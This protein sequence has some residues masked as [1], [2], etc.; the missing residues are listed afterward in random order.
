MYTYTPTHYQWTVNAQ[1]K[2]TLYFALQVIPLLS[3]TRTTRLHVLQWLFTLFR[4]QADMPPPSPS[5]ATSHSHPLA[6]SC[7]SNTSNMLSPRG[8][9]TYPS[10]MYFLHPIFIC[11]PPL[12][13]TFPSSSPNFPRLSY[14]LLFSSIFLRGSAFL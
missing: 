6:F 4:A 14:F 10:R 3:F 5:P 2:A 12:L 8:L 11:P 9:D 7:F 1:P 13:P